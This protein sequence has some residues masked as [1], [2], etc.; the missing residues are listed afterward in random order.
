M[1]VTRLTNTQNKID[2]QDFASLDPEQERIRRE[3]WLDDITY[4]YKAGSKNSITKND[5]VVEEAAIA[6][7]CYTGNIG[8]ATLTKR[9]PGAIFENITKPPYTDIFNSKT[10]AILLRNSVL[11]LRTVEDELLSQRKK[12]SGKKQQ[13][14]IHGNR[15]IVYTVMQ[16]LEI[17]QKLY[18]NIPIEDIKSNTNLTLIK[19]I[20]LLH[21]AIEKEYPDN[22]LNS[23]FKNS[24]K[25]GV[26]YNIIDKIMKS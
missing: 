7:A 14:L 23:L 25:C 20:P 24:Q 26:L 3:L 1:I 2:G 17:R 22:Y 10:N 16:H 15:F 21:D 9:N 8:L 4:H 5:I 13:A 6:L 11:V 19:I 18:Y 12:Y